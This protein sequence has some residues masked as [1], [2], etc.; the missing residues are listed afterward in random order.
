M[1]YY[2]K[3]NTNNC[4]ISRENVQAALDAI[5]KLHGPDFKK[6]YSWVHNPAGYGFSLG[7]TTLDRAIS[8]W[9]YEPKIHKSGDIEIE[10][11]RGEKLG[12]CQLFWNALA[13]FLPED[14]SVE[15]RGEDGDR[16]RY[17]FYNGKMIKQNAKIVWG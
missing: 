10:Y 12:D 13:P 8:E 5:N 6:T 16:W 1:G 9:G 3:V 7:W 15:Y 14:A 4:M 11:F 2:V 17:I